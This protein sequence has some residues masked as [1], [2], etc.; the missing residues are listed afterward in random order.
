MEEIKKPNDIFVANLSAPEA[1]VTDFIQNGI[2]AGNT[3][4]LTPDEYKA[5]PFVK[6]RYTKE[7]VFNEDAFKQDYLKA[8][9][10]YSELADA[11]SAEN[12]EK[13]LTWDKNDR[14]KPKDGKVWDTTP[15]FKKIKNPENRQYSV[16]GINA[17]SDPTWTPEEL[18][19]GNHIFDP[20]TGQFLKE[21]PESLPFY[22]KMFGE[23]LIYAKWEEDGVHTDPETGETVRHR[24]GQW[25]TDADGNYYT[26]YLG[27]R[28]LRENQV[29]AL[30]DIL[31]DEGALM[32]KV[33]FWDSDGYDKSGFGIFMK[34]AVPIA[35]AVIPYTRPYFIGLSTATGLA[36]VLPTYYKSAE[37]LFTNNDPTILSKTATKA[38]NWFRKFD[39]SKS[40]K[41]RSG[42]FNWENGAELV[43]DVL[44]QLYQQRAMAKTA[45]WFLKAPVKP[46][47][48]ATGEQII[49]YYNKYGEYAKKMNKLQSK[50]N[51]GYMAL[52]SASDVYNDSLVAGY[53]PRT[54]GITA[55]SSA[56]ALYG[57]MQYNETMNGIGNW[58]LDKTTGYS[59]ELNRGAIRKLAKD[60]MKETEKGV[61]AIDKGVP[62]KGFGKAWRK[63]L[64]KLDDALI[65]KGEEIW[66]R[67]LIEGV[68][69]VSE[70][71]V[72][73][74]IK[75]MVDAIN[76]FTHG[77]QGASFGGWSN[78]FSK[79]GAERYFTTFLG[80]AVGGGLFAIQDKIDAKIEG[81]PSTKASDYTIDQAILDGRYQELINEVPKLKK[82]FNTKQTATLGEIDGESFALS[83]NSEDQSQ[84]EV[85]AQQVLTRINT[86]ANAILRA[87]D[88]M[89][90]D[91]SLLGVYDEFAKQYKDSGFDKLYVEKKWDNLV[92]DIVDLQS[93][94][95]E[96]SKEPETEEGKAT[97][98]EDRAL[99]ETRLKEKKKELKQ[100]QEQLHNWQN[101]TQLTQN[102]LA[103]MVYLNPAIK[104]TFFNLDLKSFTQDMYD[105][106][107]DTLPATTDDGSLSQKEVKHQWELYRTA[108]DKDLLVDGLDNAVELLKKTMPW[109]A[110]SV[111]DWAKNEEA[112][113]WIRTA[114]F[115]DADGNLVNPEL[116][117]VEIDPITHEQ[118]G[119]GFTNIIDY[120]N[121]NPKLWSLYD[122]TKFDLAQALLD[123]KAINLDDYTAEEQDILKKMIN[124]QAAASG[125]TTWTPKN[126]E[127]LIDQINTRLESGDSSDIFVNTIQEMRKKAAETKTEGEG[128]AVDVTL[129]GIKT[130]DLVKVSE[131]TK[132][133]RL[134][135]ILDIV[136]DAPFIDQD[137]YRMLEQAFSEEQLTKVR[138]VLSEGL[139]TTI[140][141]T[142]IEGLFES[143]YFNAPHW[144]EGVDAEGNTVKID[145]PIVDSTAW[146][147]PENVLANQASF[148]DFANKLSTAVSS[149]N[150]ITQIDSYDKFDAGDYSTIVERLQEMVN[151]IENYSIMPLEVKA[152]WDLVKA[153]TVRENPLYKMFKDICHKFGT[154]NDDLIKYIWNLETGVHDNITG[155]YTLSEGDLQNLDD[156]VSALDFTQVLLECMSDGSKLWMGDID[157][158]S[159]K[160]KYDLVSFNGVVRNAINTGHDTKHKLDDFPI[161]SAKEID[162][163]KQVL[164]SVRRKV[165]ALYHLHEEQLNRDTRADSQLRR[166]YDVNLCLKLSQLH[167][168]LPDGKELSFVEKPFDLDTLPENIEL[169]NEQML[170]NIGETIQ[171]W[172][173]KQPDKAVALKAI[174][175]GLTKILPN[176]WSVEATLDEA[177]QQKDS[178]ISDALVY[179]AIIRSIAVTPSKL[180]EIFKK[181]LTGK[182]LIPRLD[183]ELAIKDQI[184]RNINP[185]V[186]AQSVESLHNLIPEA[187]K[188]EIEAKKAAG[189]SDPES[190]ILDNK[191]LLNHLSMASGG[192]GSGKTTAIQ[193][194][195]DALTPK[196]VLLL[197]PTQDKVADLSKLNYDESKKES[198][199]LSEF[200]G[201]DIQEAITNI[202]KAIE[203]ALSDE[204]TVKALDFSTGKD[205]ITIKPV[206]KGAEQELQ[207]KCY[208]GGGTLSNFML[209][210]E[211]INKLQ[212]LITDELINSVKDSFLV[213]DEATHLSQPE[214]ILLQAL[215]EKSKTSPLLLGDNMQLS[216]TVG[217]RG[218]LMDNGSRQVFMHRSSPL[219]GKMRFQNTG[220]AENINIVQNETKLY[221]Q[222]ERDIFITSEGDDYHDV[223]TRFYSR[224]LQ[225]HDLMGDQIATA[226]P[227][228]TEKLK[229]MAEQVNPGT[230][231]F[232]VIVD[233]ADDIDGAKKALKDAGFND[234]IINDTNIYKTVA[235]IQGAERDFIYVHSCKPITPINPDKNDINVDMHLR[236]L[237]TVISRS[238]EFTLINGVDNSLFVQ[239]GLHSKDTSISSFPDTNYSS[240]TEQ[241]LNELQAII[242]GLT[243]ITPST[244]SVEPEEKLEDED[245]GEEDEGSGIDPARPEP[246][247]EKP[248]DEDGKDD[249][250]DDSTKPSGAT[251]PAYVGMFDNAI[252]TYGY[253]KRLGITAENAKTLAGMSN[254]DQITNMMLPLY[255]GASAAERQLDLL[256]YW[257]A[258]KNTG[259]TWSTGKDLLNS[260][261]EYRNKIL[262]NTESA[263]LYI[264]IKPKD[265]T[266]FVYLKPNN[267]VDFEG[268][269]GTALTSLVAEKDGIYI[270]IGRVGVNKPTSENGGMHVYSESLRNMWEHW[271]TNGQQ[272]FFWELSKKSYTSPTGKGRTEY[273]KSRKNKNE[274]IIIPEIIA[275]SGLRDARVE[276]IPTNGTSQANGL[277]VSDELLSLGRMSVPDLL[278]LGYTAVE[279]DT[280]R[281][282]A[283]A[284]MKF[285]NS[286]RIEP[287]ENSNEYYKQIADLRQKHWIAI[288]PKGITY[289]TP[290]PHT[291]LVMVQQVETSKTLAKS[292]K[293][294]KS[295]YLR[296]FDAKLILHYL[297]WL[298]GYKGDSLQGL[299]GVRDQK[300]RKSE[301]EIKAWD[302]AIE[303]FA[304]QIQSGDN[305]DSEK[306]KSFVGTYGITDNVKR[307]KLADAIRQFKSDG[308]LQPR[309]CNYKLKANTVTDSKSP[310]GTIISSDYSKGW[311]FAKDTS[312]SLPRDW[313]NNNTLVVTRTFEE[314]KG[315]VDM[316]EFTI[317]KPQINLGASAT[318]G[319]ATT[320]TGTSSSTSTGTTE[321]WRSNPVLSNL[322]QK[323]CDLS[324]GALTFD[325]VTAAQIVEYVENNKE[326][327]DEDVFSSENIE[328]LENL[329]C[330]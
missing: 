59:P 288:T 181:G 252:E 47:E 147:T 151:A 68:E 202:N 234:S 265:D 63:F 196:K 295:G 318:V 182:S 222:Q 218:V 276:N 266:D 164:Y 263:H 301:D 273:N 110:S 271:D 267:H 220:K 242:D 195:V 272:H 231:T 10:K 125:V 292:I 251:L 190:D 89:K 53:D 262:Y 92:H 186:Y 324:N 155:S 258:Q 232:A 15:A 70:E 45:N 4:F 168:E 150:T 111:A 307:K 209:T 261:V 82:F 73:D 304:Q 114:P 310:I 282:D 42:F 158:G 69:E 328:N 171:D 253:Y 23:T 8:Y 49:D 21:T 217:A 14:Y 13:Y 120:L 299:R 176:A 330:S 278:R 143:N 5:T 102:T 309:S 291:K 283:A 98:K 191:L 30:G 317:G 329:T 237:Y 298:T 124:Q 245:D 320:S 323:L 197:A 6:K 214:L 286:F 105:K 144:I 32:N 107:F 274:N 215:A 226:E 88:G 325:S 106:D 62:Y 302:D 269:N 66:K 235:N 78:V 113:N 1:G 129:N 3:S 260:F 22:K 315:I 228:V 172:I 138:K 178:I 90:Y 312:S 157:T 50:F 314:P 86:R 56:A 156:I 296:Q 74:S 87:T 17:I 126:L 213:I 285:Y 212:E 227:E 97:S 51:L 153:K 135:S 75:G 115:W 192:A 316:N 43:T 84:A 287:I 81:R 207:F 185:E 94:I 101:G 257:N 244:T 230:K 16:Q 281:M 210:T 184:A 39:S 284:F 72:Q 256:G 275:I 76:S 37:A 128:A 31:T 91:K 200:W 58:M 290:N 123:E 241:R 311:A 133:I 11:E 259:K 294:T 137:L 35:L 65:I 54:A 211:S 7:G 130:N 60:L 300:S 41:G 64:S 100:K 174:T 160:F 167:L 131:L 24:K 85:I 225:Y 203:D 247:D 243:H 250:D 148:I 198:K 36:S 223:K 40:Y 166:V 327:I 246:K 118:K 163:A 303:G 204:A 219:S 27:N 224:P 233:S 194:M 308:L 109:A 161:F 99:R 79:E 205:T 319:G 29:V 255:D 249:G 116:S 93:S 162:N 238:K 175:D 28:D 122:A 188:S 136:Q 270:T 38:E 48:G 326:D 127:V 236:K 268:A 19:Q 149:L 264:S 208:S 169:A 152:K 254:N 80:G 229:Q 277:G 173:N 240:L 12:L 289:S 177:C 139:K 34:A 199:V 206:I 95:A 103:M 239:Y 322:V 83:A 26:E 305:F 20:E 183:Q 165:G 117:A 159:F 25:K 104:N 9:E 121:N 67:S 77:Q 52:I 44:L 248:K 108:L 112:K 189:E 134:N 279:V 145:L 179:N 201:K 180:D 306:W 142:T 61:Q 18:A 146:A 216:K 119:V 141:D 187:I 313:E 71:A 293:P 221:S 55:L 57:I 140:G 280:S 193:I 297:E 2:V 321:A 96:L 170:T 154:T 33:D 132:K 46:G